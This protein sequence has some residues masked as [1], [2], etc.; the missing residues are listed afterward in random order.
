M[1]VTLTIYSCAHC[2]QV[3]GDYDGGLGTIDYGF[4]LIRL[5]HPNAPG[6]PD[7]YT[8]VSLY[9]EPVGWLLGVDPK[10]AGV[11]GCLDPEAAFA[12]LVAL[13]EE[14]GLYDD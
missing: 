9:K 6:R 14:L 1:T 5:C 13:T 4:G 11:E 12:E 10:P 3:C 8:R 2:G 7:C